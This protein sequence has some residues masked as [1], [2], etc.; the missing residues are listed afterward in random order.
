MSDS[1]PTVSRTTLDRE[2]EALRRRI[3]KMGEEVIVTLD[4]AHQALHTC[5]AELARFI[6][7]S[8]AEINEMRFE[9]ESRCH[10]MIATQQP[11][12]RDLREILCALSIATELERM[13]D[14]SAGIA[15]T[16]LRMQNSA[17]KSLPRGLANM[18]TIVR[19]M[20]RKALDA[21]VQGDV[22][23][24]YMVASEDDWVDSQY[25]VLFKEL[26]DMMVDEPEA[27]DTILYLLF[28][29]HNLER[30]GDRVTNIVERTIFAESGEIRE[31][32]T[33][34]GVSSFN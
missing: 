1:P 6:I 2:L 33:E 22:D 11:A 32:N 13:G 20:L 9:I 19:E 25:Q 12:A 8:D 10:G 18:V 14:H 4:Q 3:F 26:L 5:D 24:A 34:D 16:V 15:K 29:G 23:L 7:A 17:Y 21:Y 28:S 27:I 30:I 31:L